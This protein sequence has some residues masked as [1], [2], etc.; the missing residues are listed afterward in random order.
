MYFIALL[1]NHNFMKTG[2][3]ITCFCFL[4]TGC[5]TSIE[6]EQPEGI[7][8]LKGLAGEK[9]VY[10][11]DHMVTCTGVAVQQCMLVK[12]APGDAWE[13]W[14]DGIKD[15]E[16]QAGTSYVLRII[17]KEITNP[18]QDASSIEWELIEVLKEF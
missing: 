16:H 14:Y 12:E 6:R 15:F 3:L 4:L 11:D 9:I 7:F 18:P 8:E 17:E 5:D 13:Y 10:V 2:F 1:V